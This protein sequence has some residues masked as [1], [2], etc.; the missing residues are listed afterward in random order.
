MSEFGFI[1]GREDY[2]VC[3]E[4][5]S[6]EVCNDYGCDIV[7]AESEVVLGV[8]QVED[9]GHDNVKEKDTLNGT[10]FNRAGDWY[11]YHVKAEVK[12]SRCV[13]EFVE[14]MKLSKIPDSQYQKLD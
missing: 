5:C 6:I 3:I 11:S 7:P 2:I 9:F 10:L 1:V 14:F 12:Y 13:S 8:D 4:Y